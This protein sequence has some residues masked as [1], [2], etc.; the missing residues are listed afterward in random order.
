MT[1]HSKEYDWCYE[2]C[3]RCGC[4]HDMKEKEKYV[5][6]KVTFTS[7][8]DPDQNVFQNPRFSP[9]CGTA[10]NDKINLFKVGDYASPAVQ[11]VAET[12]SC[13]ML[14]ELMEQQ[15]MMG[16][17]NFKIETDP[18][19]SPGEMTFNIKVNKK[20]HYVSFLRMI[21]PSPDWF[22]GVDSV[23]L[24]DGDKWK[25]M[26]EVDIIAYNAWTDAG[27]MPHGADMPLRPP[28]H[29]FIAVMDV[30]PLQA[31]PMLGKIKF[32]RV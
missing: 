1:K 17:A 5:E 3:Q 30:G 9:I 15:K 4:V 16:N 8:W 2:K 32:E 28:K 18:M 25:D 21:V 24:R 11:Q 22:V 19:L 23:D 7:T 13:E 20:Y 6:Y 26:E 14:F 31:M 10:H 27:D 12:G 29:K